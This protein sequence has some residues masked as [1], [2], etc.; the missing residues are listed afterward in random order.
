[1]IWAVILLLVLQPVHG[2]HLSLGQMWQMFWNLEM[3]WINHL[4]FMGTLV[5][6]YLLYPLIRMAFDGNRRIFYY[7]T[8]VCVLLSFGNTLLNAG[9][10]ALLT[11]L[12]GTPTVYDN[13]AFSYIFDPF[14]SSIGYALAYFCIG[15]ILFTLEDRIRAVA[16]KKRNLMAALG[17]LLSC[18]LLWFLGVSY[19]IL[20][21]RLWDVVWDGYDSVFTLC[22]VVCL[23]ILS[24][25]LKKDTWLLRTVSCNTIGI[26]FTHDVLNRIMKVRLPAVDWLYSVPGTLVYALILLSCSLLL[27]LMM[28]KIPLVS[29]LV[30]S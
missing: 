17:I 12:R 23:F 13:F 2:Q 22:N 15:G 30:G 16:P 21:R 24:L 6:I 28:R 11:V 18:G 9:V 10:T 14:A 7:F 27:C 25:S 29:R 3:G 8:A 5:G 1:M 20:S 4:W 19:S 26:Y